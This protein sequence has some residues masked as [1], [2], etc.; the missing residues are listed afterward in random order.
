M[1]VKEGQTAKSDNQDNYEATVLD[2]LDKEMSAAQ[3]S[4]K[5]KEYS[6]ELDELVTGLLKQVIHEAD[7]KK[8]AQN[9]GVESLDDLIAEFSPASDAPGPGAKMDSSSKSGLNS[10]SAATRTVSAA[11][12]PE[13]AKAADAESPKKEKSAKT[14][15]HK[16]AGSLFA[17]PASMAKRKT[18][19]IAAA[20]AG[21]LAI[22]GGAVY[23]FSNSGSSE[24]KQPA[25]PTAAVSPAP[26]VAGNPAAVQSQPAASQPQAAAVSTKDRA[27]G[28]DSTKRAAASST[29]KNVKSSDTRTEQARTATAKTRERVEPAAQQPAASSAAVTP[30]PPRME[31]PAPIPAAPPVVSSNSD[32]SERQPA[33]AVAETTRQPE[34]VVERKPAPVV[35]AEPKPASVAPSAPVSTASSTPQPQPSAPVAAKTAAPAVPI[36]RANPKFPELA[37]RTRASGTVVLDVTIDAQGKVIKAKPV[38]G[39]IVFHDE[40]VKAAMKW[41][42]KPASIEGTNVP[43]QNRITFNFNLKQ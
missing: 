35:P 7:G 14:D 8:P 36:S 2:F 13:A 30:A 31:T 40:A 27:A 23:F 5:Q 18:P 1:T 24:S 15:G 10:G 21:L 11:V 16:S 6:E 3:P 22:I 17:S 25:A 20:C 19:I 28:T 37:L 43:S 32:S 33:P 26:P 41:R 38:S 39:P 9:A 12:L 4:P 42:Y 34:P 29:P